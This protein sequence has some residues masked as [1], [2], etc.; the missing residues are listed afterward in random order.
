M[1]DSTQQAMFLPVGR[2]AATTSWESDP[3]FLKQTHSF[4]K[5]QRIRFGTSEASRPTDVGHAKIL[6]SQTGGPEGVRP[7]PLRH[8]QKSKCD[9]CD[10]QKEHPGHKMACL[11]VLVGRIVQPLVSWCE[12]LAFLEAISHHMPDIRRS[13]G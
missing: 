11:G 2:R 3:F 1:R 12:N 8:S 13:T 4:E 9:H 5:G 6:G 10:H 7:T